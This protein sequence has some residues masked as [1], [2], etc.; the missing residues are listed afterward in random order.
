MILIVA[1][2]I[3]KNSSGWKLEAITPEELFGLDANNAHVDKGFIS[4]SWDQ[5]KFVL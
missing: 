3:A 5:S 1:E 4:L 2:V